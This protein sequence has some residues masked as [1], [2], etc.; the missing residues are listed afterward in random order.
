MNKLP[1]LS[2]TVIA[3]TQAALG[4]IDVLVNNAGLMW[5]GP[6]VDESESAEKARLFHHC[7]GLNFM[8]FLTTVQFLTSARVLTTARAFAPAA[9]NYHLV[10][11]NPS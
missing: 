2:G 9:M 7:A 4:P 3:V 11:R 5:V 1:N 8:Q 6:F 10:Y